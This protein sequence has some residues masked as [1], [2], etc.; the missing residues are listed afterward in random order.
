MTQTHPIELPERNEKGLTALEK[1]KA[2]IIRTV[3]DFTAADHMCVAL[4]DMEKE[5]DKAYDEHIKSAHEAH[6]SLV[7]KKKSYAE[8]LI[9]ARR[10]LKI[11]MDAFRE[12]QEAK[13]REDERKLQEQARKLAEDQALADAAAAEGEGDH[14]G[15]KAILEAPIQPALIVLP[16]STPKTSTSIRKVWDWRVK[17]PV[18]VPDEYW[19]LDTVKIGA[20]VRA[21]KSKDCIPGIECFEKVA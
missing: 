19:V 2:L 9:E 7:A 12:A 15:A 10:V 17:D 1:A 11:S 4:K 13:R 3:E 5:V 20:V 14:E 18:K 21:K 6:K 8:P 16:K